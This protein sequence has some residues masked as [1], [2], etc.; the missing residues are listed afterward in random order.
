MITG[1]TRFVPLLA[2]PCRHVRTPPLFNAEC[3]R[4]GE[5]IIMVALDVEPDRLS[6]TVESFRAIENVAGM[7]ITIPH[8]GAVAALCDRLIGAAELV[9]ACNVV[10]REKDGSLTGGMF[11]GEGFV[12]GLLHRG[13]DPAGR[14]VLLVGAGGAASGV[15]HAL[16]RAGVANLTIANR[17]PEKAEALAGQL[18]G[19]FSAA[20]VDVGM[21]DPRGFDI[22]VNGTALGMH[23]GDALPVDVDRLDAGTVVAEVVMQPDVTP[24]L[25]EAKARGCVV[26]KGIHMIEQQVRLLVDFL[27]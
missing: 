15:A 23:A 27:K 3:E 14:R 24:L 18:R 19:F 26:H 2:H 9:G 11:D 6:A 17:S 12:A 21:P 8:K 10:R 13:H 5:D 16:L 22:V 1:H 4:Q 7:V 20:Q 25:A